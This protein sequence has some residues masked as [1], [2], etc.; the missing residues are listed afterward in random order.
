[1]L[2]MFHASVVHAPTELSSNNGQTDET[3]TGLEI[4]KSFASNFPDVVQAF[5]P[6]GGMAYTHHKEPLLMPRLDVLFLLSLFI[7]SLC[8][9]LYT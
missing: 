6:K 7:I 1:M 8:L 2:A 3:K 4:I 9:S 5:L